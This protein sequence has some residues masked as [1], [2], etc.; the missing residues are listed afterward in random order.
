MNQG[1]IPK[2][3]AKALYEFAAEQGNDSQV[4][5]VMRTLEQSFEANPELQKA[6]A[7]PFVSP[8]DKAA[9]IRTAAGVDA[10]PGVL[11]D[12]LELLKRNERFGLT[13]G[14]ALAYCDI[15]R[16]A[17]SIDVVRVVSAAPL[18]PATE[19]RLKS[20]IAAHL[21][22]HTMEYSSGV[23]PELIGGFTVQTGNTRLDASVANELKQLRLNLISK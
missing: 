5:A 4:Y 22:A 10:K 14:I 12:F 3:Y 13:R 20:I 11:T 21:G 15:Y 18:D 6:L 2:R 19:S 9:L 1:L 7:N 23:D 8:A 17:H 16:K